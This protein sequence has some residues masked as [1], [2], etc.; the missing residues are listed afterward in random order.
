MKAGFTYTEGNRIKIALAVVISFAGILCGMIPYGCA[1]AILSQFLAGNKDFMML[2]VFV[3]IAFVAYIFSVLGNTFST[4]ISHNIAF[5]VLERVRLQLLDKMTKLP[6]GT[7]RSRA[8]GNW[9]QF[10]GETMEK[11]EKP[12]AHIIP[13]VTSNILASLLMILFVFILDWRLGLANLATIP[14]GLIF[15]LL[16]MRNYEEQSK[17]HME[18]SKVMNATI[19]EYVNGIE[20][21]KAFNQTASSYGKYKESVEENRRSVLEWSKHTGKAMAATIELLPSTLLFVLPAGIY[22]FMQG[23][24][25]PQTILLC[26]MLAMST[27][28]P[29]IRAMEYVAT[30]S[31]LRVVFG[32]INSVMLQPELV[33]PKEKQIVYSADVSFNNVSFRY[34]KNQ[35]TRSIDEKNVLDNVNLYC[36]EGELTAIVGPSGS[37]KSTIASLMAGF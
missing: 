13:E 3:A 20:V 35:L 25:L 5:L 18:A 17:R 27:M 6:M 7:I 29:L 26:V 15:Y 14:L 33:R 24:I 1:A 23:A 22:L 10:I 19:A 28:Q 30:V 36:K 31:N 11:L 16:M 9:S 2:F 34:E 37:G 12:I 4:I 8:S 32:E 21:I